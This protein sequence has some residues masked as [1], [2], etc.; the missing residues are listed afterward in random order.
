MKREWLFFGMRAKTPASLSR[1]DEYLNNVFALTHIH[2]MPV[3]P[4]NVN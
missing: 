4:V 2:I 3:C 1:E